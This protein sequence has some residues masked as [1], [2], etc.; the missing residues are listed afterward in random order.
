M[1]TLFIILAFMAAGAGFYVAKKGYIKDEDNDG[2]PDMVEDTIKEVKAKI[3]KAK[4][5]KN[6]GKQKS[7]L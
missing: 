5:K 3:K 4:N 2:V 1:I 7:S 6:N